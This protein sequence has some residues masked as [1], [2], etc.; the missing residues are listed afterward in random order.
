MSSAFNGE[1][2]AIIAHTQRYRDCCIYIGSKL[3][4]EECTKME[5]FQECIGF[6]SP[7][8]YG[9]IAVVSGGSLEWGR[10]L[11]HTSIEST[12]HCEGL[13]TGEQLHAC[14]MQPL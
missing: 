7:H 12:S 1:F 11:L 3:T 4:F 13:Q 9:I 8:L 10:V 6:L 5:G 14:V 2:K